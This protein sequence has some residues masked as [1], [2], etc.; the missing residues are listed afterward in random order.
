MV[1]VTQ[2]KR[3]T[4]I[5]HKRRHGKHHKPSPDYHKAYWPYLPLGIIVGLGMLV[6]AFW[7]TIQ[8]SVLSYATN[9]SV[10]SLLQETNEERIGTGL[11]GLTLNAQLNQAAQAKADD[12]AARD[13][14]SHN[15]PDGNPPWVFFTNAGYSYQA[16]GEN[17]AYG[18]D[19]STEAVAGWM[20]SPGHKA[21]ILNDSYKEVGFGI[22][23][24]ADYQGTG[25]ETIVVAMYASPR[26]LAAGGSSKPTPAAPTPKPAPAPAEPAPAPVEAPPEPT[27]APT[28]EETN[29]TPVV[30]KKPD[31]K[32][33]TVTAQN[34][35]RVQLLAGTNASW[36]LF[37]ASAIATISIAI[38]FLRHG[39]LWHR[40]LVKSEAFV[41]KHLF[42]DIVLVSLATIS[43]I[44]SQTDGI[45]R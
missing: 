1:L 11:N 28:K 38:F 33:T 35:S 31:Q 39:L 17:L 9:M 36:S 10:S 27:P 41:H 25:P 34:I 12:M 45:I 6:N 24:A 14:W 8:Q 42:L 29:T 7:G 30:A 43:L 20:N 40:V 15:T 13:Y 5:H 18:F 26:V 19:S 21:N 23:N 3:P 2:K 22:A 4:S 37:A 16:A 44:L 32:P